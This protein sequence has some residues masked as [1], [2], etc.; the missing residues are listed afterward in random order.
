M[1]EMVARCQACGYEQAAEFAQC[2]VCVGPCAWWCVACHAWRPG[3]RCPSCDGQLSVP[4]LVEL[5]KH[6]PGALVEFRFT[7]RNA[8]KKAVEFAVLPGDPALKVPAHRYMLK[9]ASAIEIAGTLALGPFP[10]GRR[11]Y[12]V[13]FDAA[14]PV[15]TQLVVEVVAP[16]VRVAFTPAEVLFKNGVPGKTVRRVVAVENNGNARIAA[17][18]LASESWLSVTPAQVELEPGESTSLKVVAKTRKTEFGLR[19]ARVRIEADTGHSWDLPVRVQLPEP[20]LQAAAVDL[21]IVPPGRAA[22]ETLTLRNVGKVRVA[23]TLAAE[24]TWFTVS[25]TRVN[26]PPGREKIVKIKAVL[27]EQLAGVRASAVVVTFAGGPPLR[28]PVSAVCHVPKPFLGPIRRQTLA[29]ATDVSVVRRFAVRN[30]GDGKLDCTVSAVVPWIEILT[31]KLRVG[32]GKKRRVEFRIDTPNM[33]LGVNVAT[34]CVRSNGGTADVPISVT[35]VAPSPELEVLGDI[36]LGTVAPDRIVGGYLS[37]RNVGVG[38]L[39]LRADPEDARVTVTP[40]EANIAPGPPSRLAVSVA[41]EGLPGGPHAFGVRF[42]SNGGTGR[43]EVRFRLP[44]ELI[45]APSVIDLGDRPAGRS[46]T[47]ALRVRNTGPDPVSLRL[48]SEDPWLSLTATEVIV[49]PGEMVVVSFRMDLLPGQSGPVMSTIWLEGHVFRA[50]VMVRLVA[51]KVDLVVIPHVLVLGDMLTGEDRTVTFQV[52]NMGEIAADIRE[53]HTVG[54]LEVVL[55][56]STVK[57]GETATVAARVR[58]NARAVGKQVRRA[59]HLTD[60]VVVRFSAKVTCSVVPNIV[61]AVAVVGGIVVGGILAV[62]VGWFFGAAVAVAG[63]VVA[64]V[65]LA[66]REGQ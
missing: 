14:I 42:A 49:R 13:R 66:T 18:V 28:V 27:H 17:R 38:L 8:S 15:E 22:F 19:A 37:V 36:E 20:A 11:T 39:A 57:P 64:G 65:F 4:P 9:A 35:V 50:S 24:E 3:R 34:I 46:L 5:G 33:P 54:E 63:V 56:R 40:A 60:E 43:A 2:P 6:P 47:E 53:S 23:C 44:V 32:P 58:M 45:D 41:V 51:R 52:A 7:V 16:V 12:Q 10:P 26:L 21:G 1:S 59:V 30:I 48:R 55:R 29:V 31:P 62:T 61:A 25:P